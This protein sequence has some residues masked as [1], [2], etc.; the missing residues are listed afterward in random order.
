MKTSED[1]MKYMHCAVGRE[2]MVKAL[3]AIGI[4]C[5]TIL[6]ADGTVLRANGEGRGGAGIAVDRRASPD[7][8]IVGF[9]K[10]VKRSSRAKVHAALG[11]ERLHGYR[12]IAADV[13]RIPDGM[14]QKALMEAYRQHPD[15][16]Y[17]EPNYAITAD[18][19][20]N[21]PRFGELWGL[22][23]TGQTGGTADKDIFAEAAWNVTTG[24]SDVIVA[25]IDTGID[26]T[27]P[28]LADNMWTNPD[29]VADG[30]DND[31]NGI[32]DDIYGARWVSGDGIPTN[33][34][35]MDGKGHG[36]HCAGTIGAVGNNGIGVVGVNWQVR[37]MALKFLPDSGSGTTADAISAIEYAIDK[38]AHLSSNSWGGGGFS[39]AMK[40]MIEAAGA[41]NQLF[42]AAAGNAT[43]DN[44]ATPHYPCSYTCDNIIAVASS[45]HNDARSWFSNWGETSVDLAAPGSDILSTL[46]SA[47][48][49]VYNGTSMAT[50]HVSGVA[51]LLLAHHGLGTDHATLKALILDNVDPVVAFDGLVVTNGRL[52]AAAALAPEFPFVVTPYADFIAA[53]RL[54]GPISPESFSYVLANTTGGPRAWTATVSEAWLELDNPGGTLGAGQSVTVTVSLAA[55]VDAFPEGLYTDEIVFSDGTRTVVRQAR[56]SVAIDYFTEMF[57]STPN[58]LSYLSVTF[59]PDGSPAEFYQAFTDP[60]NG[61]PVDPADG[62]PISLGDDSFEQVNLADGKQVSLFGT[63][64]ASFYVCAN[65]YITFLAG[66][67]EYSHSPGTH[68][69]VPRISGFFLDFSPQN[70]ASISWKQL[71]D[72]AV[73]TYEN[74]PQWGMADSSNFQVE[75][76]YDGTI[77]ITWLRMDAESGLVGLSPGSGVP[78]PF[79]SS[80]M[81]E[82]PTRLVAVTCGRRVDITADAAGIAAFTKKPKVLAT[83]YD[84]VKDPLRQKPK[85]AALKVLTKIGKLGVDSVSCEWTKAVKLFDAKAFKAAQ[86]AGSTA[87]AWLT[88][89]PA[90]VTP[91]SPVISGK[92]AAEG[93]YR[94]AVANLRLVWP[95]V[96]Q[97]L[98]EN[99]VDP[100]ARA[101]AG[102]TMVVAGTDFGA[103][104]P[105]AWLEYLDAKGAVKP[106]KLK[107]LKPY[108]YSN[109]QGK[110]L[111]SCM[112]PDNGDSMV[113]LLMPKSFPKDWRHDLDHNLVLDNKVGMASFPFGTQAA[114][115]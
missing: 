84:L 108:A 94:Q 109:A 31:G 2:A 74:M 81:S 9:S 24:S 99:G 62:T 55:G 71:A 47:S 111:A 21:D 85:R 68:F 29:E 75:M 115:D 38:G 60:V 26:Y 41:A 65:G 72:R 79:I 77:R 42:V 89:N 18:A 48:Y 92:E 86:K 39:I 69:S 110:E 45:D 61:F 44:D 13:V 64:Y 40:E 78:P 3:V 28:D 107:V 23:N 32:V 14:S 25:V 53:G 106:L 67:E 36:T 20:P 51:A 66:D 63:Q 46:P 57:D 58:D 59:T 30:I 15:V 95:Q 93:P 82:Y 12:R 104:A 22:K 11:V 33:G 16:A 70:G 37:L 88:Q 113:V 10:G 5:A 7:T 98:A 49:G 83:Y 87:A 103:K 101:G 90:R 8:L 91:L 35:P 34:D 73:V 97:V 54:G 105:K 96:T 114:G 52:N 1:F 80:D 50:P 43:L 19:L 56:L 17:V 112:D 100:I 27:H 4:L 76:F 102:Q 6:W